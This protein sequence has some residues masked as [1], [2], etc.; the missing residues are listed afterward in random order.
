VFPAKDGSVCAVREAAE[1]GESM[2]LNCDGGFGS[3]TFVT[4]TFGFAAAARAVA[5]LAGG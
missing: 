1:A 5:R 3:A 4:G 2:R